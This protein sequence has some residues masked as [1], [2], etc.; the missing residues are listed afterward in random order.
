MKIGTTKH[1]RALKWILTNPIFVA[2][3]IGAIICFI[4]DGCQGDPVMGKGFS[5]PSSWGRSCLVLAPAPLSALHVTGSNAGYFTFAG[6]ANRSSHPT[7]PPVFL[8]DSSFMLTGPVYPA[9]PTAGPVLE[10]LDIP[11]QGSPVVGG[12]LAP[13]VKSRASMDVER[14]LDAIVLV[15][16]SGRCDAV[17]DGENA[18][19]AY[20]IRPIFLRDVNRIL[21]CDR[22]TLPDRFDPVKSR[23]MAKIFLNHYGKEKTLLEMA[24]QFNG[25]PRG[26]LKQ[27]TL[28]YAQKVAAILN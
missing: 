20:Q 3:A 1:R 17:N 5:S 12:P 9:L 23:Q 6:G 8:T 11:R 28:C 10:G 16:S 26:H 21:G 24:R 15:E 18:A 22:Y 7:A 19:G 2:L 25:G 14:L 27:A 13:A 4:G